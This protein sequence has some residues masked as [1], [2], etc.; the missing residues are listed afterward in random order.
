MVL[1]AAVRLAEIVA[2]A[3]LVLLAAVRLAGPAAEEELALLLL[4]VDGLALVL[5]VAAE[6]SLEPS[7]ML[8]MVLCWGGWSKVDIRRIGIG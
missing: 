4:R 2:A 7:E 8:L 6:S 3:V 1:L 5:L